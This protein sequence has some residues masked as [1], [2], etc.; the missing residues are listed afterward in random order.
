MPKSLV[1][2][3]SVA[4]W[5]GSQYQAYRA[6]KA[7][8]QFE[9]RHITAYK[10][11]YEFP[12]DIFL[13]V[14]PVK[15][16]RPEQVISAATTTG[17][18]DECVEQLHAADLIHLW[19]T[20][21][22]EPSLLGLGLPIDYKKARV[23]TMTGSFYRDNHTALNVAFRELGCRVT[24]QDANLKFP[25]E[26]DSTFIPHAV[27]IEQFEPL[28]EDQRKKSVGTYKNPNDCPVRPTG[29]DVIK[30]KEAL[31]EWP[32]WMVELDYT[33]PWHERMEKLRECSVFVQDISPHMGYW[34]RSALE[35]AALGIP[36]ITNY[37]NR[38]VRQSEGKLGKIPLINCEWDNIGLKL[39]TL[40]EDED[41][42]KTVGRS[43]REWIK[44]HFSH[45]VVGDMYSK[46][47]SEVL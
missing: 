23:V 14:F 27:P 38:A 30:L 6:V 15:N 18:Y 17:G 13:P 35:A 5:A 20:F 9:C 36:T 32:D 11:D 39:K 26:I 7:A 16:V 33:M 47:Y 22:G 3:V 4:D 25:E 19:N 31:E 46:L 21:P 29:K 44:K 12:R 37:S 1:V 45:G 2:I 28:P 34:G 41:Y 24:V 10:H 40:I 42:R 43:C 8:G